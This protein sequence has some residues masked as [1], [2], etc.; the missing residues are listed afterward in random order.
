MLNSH[1]SDDP[2]VPKTASVSSAS[3]SLGVQTVH[4]VPP[5]SL[6]A[7]DDAMDVDTPA[8]TTTTTTTPTP[9]PRAES[10]MLKST[11]QTLK[12]NDVTRDNAADDHGNAEEEE[13]ENENG[14]RDNDSEKQVDEENNDHEE[15]QSGGVGEDSEEEDVMEIDENDP[16][17]QQIL[18]DR[19]DYAE[20][21]QKRLRVRCVLLLCRLFLRWLLL[22]VVRCSR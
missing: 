3:T 16:R 17:R 9:P 21:Q 12:A 6:A 5:R 15:D 13:N 11:E 1:L 22:C 14:D 19:Q 18:S 7:G 20:L 8:T 4:Q 10:V 2:A